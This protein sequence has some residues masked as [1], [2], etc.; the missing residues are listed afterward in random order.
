MASLMRLARLH[1]P[2]RPLRIDSVPRPE[3]RPDDVLVQVKSCG[4]IPNMNAIF[5]GKLWN[6]L[7]PLP[8]SVGLDAA[9][10][11]AEVG[12]NVTQV[13]VGQRVYVNP[14]LACG[15]C[16]YCRAHAPLL[17]SAAAFQG[18]FGFF[19]HSLPQLARYPFGGFSE[20]MTAAP[21]RLVILPDAVAFD[22]AARFGYT[23]TSFA[24][25][26]LGNVGAGT[27]LAVNGITGTL[28]VAAALLALGMGATRILGLGRNRAVL[29][30]LSALAPGRIRTRALDDRPVADWMRDETDGLGVDVLLDCSARA[31]SASVTADAL[32][33]LKRGGM[34]VNI[35]ALSEPLA[36]QPMR[37]MTSRIGLRGSNWFTTGEGQLMA[38]M[39]ARG[40]LDLSH[41]EP[42]PFPL[43]RVNDALDAIKARPGGFVNIV[44]NPDQ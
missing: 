40:V 11:V 30:R 35:G 3:P 39:A 26:R 16:A 5:S 33:G 41:L 4:V 8:A 32:N 23:G 44:V 10:V 24:A 43:E 34:A 13:R 27:W 1:E 38:E 9:G 22:Q 29:D 6:Q 36:I 19:P 14:W 42:R 7:P 37:F 18:Y 12:E 17:C 31:A 21:Q 20:Y 25:L 15:Q 28:G 2:G